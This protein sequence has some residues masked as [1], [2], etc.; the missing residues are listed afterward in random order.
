MI[1]G[2]SGGGGGGAS[3]DELKSSAFLLAASSLRRKRFAQRNQT[4]LGL[5]RLAQR[6]RQHICL[7]FVAAV[8]RTTVPHNQR[9]PS[10]CSRNG[11]LVSGSG[12]RDR[13]KRTHTHNPLSLGRSRASQREREKGRA[14]ANRWPLSVHLLARPRWLASVG[15]RDPRQ[16]RCPSQL[17]SPF[18]LQQRQQRPRLVRAQWT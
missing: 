8:A 13:A 7:P 17:L 14:R 15:A 12:D 2:L 4:R 3:D 18:S 5:P 6:Q 9:K 10:S 11:S 16:A 1:A